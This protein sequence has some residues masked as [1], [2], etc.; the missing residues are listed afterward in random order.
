M[1]RDLRGHPWGFF[2]GLRGLYY[3]GGNERVSGGSHRGCFEGLNGVSLRCF[4]GLRGSSYS[5]FWGVSRG[6]H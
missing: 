3:I 1:F 5:L 4:E 2:E 6:S